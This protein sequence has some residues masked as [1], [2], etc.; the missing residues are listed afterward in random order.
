MLH[1]T[2]IFH[3]FDNIESYLYKREIVL[4]LIPIILSISYLDYYN[5]CRDSWCVSSVRI[6]DI[7]GIFVYLWFFLLKFFLV[8][9]EFH[10]PLIHCY[11]EIMLCCGNIVDP[12]QVNQCLALERI[13]DVQNVERFVKDANKFA[14]AL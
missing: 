2:F 5:L 6:S 13:H 9:N 8:Q 10:M 12:R 7:L 4:K 1:I 3:F 14:V 11:F